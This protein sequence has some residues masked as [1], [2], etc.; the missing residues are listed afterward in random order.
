MREYCTESVMEVTPETR[1][2]TFDSV[3]SQYLLCQILVSRI[4]ANSRYGHY[5]NEL[6]FMV[7]GENGLDRVPE[8]WPYLEFAPI[9]ET[10]IWH[11]RY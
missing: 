10:N 2:S 11:K 7:Y 8:K 3:G 5:A 6:L 4:G 9:L 1:P